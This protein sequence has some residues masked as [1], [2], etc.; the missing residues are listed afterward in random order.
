MTAETSID[1]REVIFIN[2]DA[3][4]SYDALP[5]AI[6]EIADGVVTLLQNG[7]IPALKGLWQTLKGKLR[8]IGEIRINEGTDT[9]RVYIW[10]GCEPA[11]YVLDAGIKKSPTGDEIPQWQRERLADRR[12]RA[13]RH[14]EDNKA[15]L[16]QAF[17]ERAARRQ[18]NERGSSG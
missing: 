9:Y 16:E 6:G 8:G 10:Q 7:Q 15:D 4:R 14:C 13:A 11:L 18:R 12:T 1:V 5:A 3:E 17:T 2:P